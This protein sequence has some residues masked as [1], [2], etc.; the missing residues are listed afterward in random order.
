L[1]TV[2]VVGWTAAP[3]LAR[4]PTVGVN[5]GYDRRLIESRK[6]LAGVDAAAVRAG[7]GRHHHSRQ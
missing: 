5:P 6:A 1:A 7:R 3:A 2:V 4:P